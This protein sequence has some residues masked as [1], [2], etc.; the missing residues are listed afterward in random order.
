[1]FLVTSQQ[2]LYL[3]RTWCFSEYISAVYNCSCIAV[4][5]LKNVGKVFL[6]SS[7][8]DQIIRTTIYFDNILI[9]DMK[10]CETLRAEILNLN[11]QSCCSKPS[12]SFLS[13]MKKSISKD[14]FLDRLGFETV[15]F[16][17]DRLISSNDIR[18]FN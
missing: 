4:K 8:G 16:N 7:F 6:T 12:L 1:M 2:I 5:D 10:I 11:V 13:V 18:A 9:Q 3:H 17:N 15:Q 14:N